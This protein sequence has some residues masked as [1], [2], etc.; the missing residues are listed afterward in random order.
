MCA[1]FIKLQISK[2]ANA[3]LVKRKIAAKDDMNT[4]VVESE[5]I[6][7]KEVDYIVQC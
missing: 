4:V 3:T 6:R 7:R 5:S 2:P 1:V